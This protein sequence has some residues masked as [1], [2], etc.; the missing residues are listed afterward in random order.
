VG[1]LAFPYHDGRVSSGSSIVP[2]KLTTYMVFIK[3]LRVVERS[4]ILKLLEE[5]HISETGVIDPSTAKEM[6]RIL[7]I[8]VIVTGTLIDLGRGKTEI[9]AR[10]LMADTGEII[11][12]SQAVIKTTWS[13]RPRMIGANIV[14]AKKMK[15]SDKGNEAIEIGVPSR[16]GSRRRSLGRS[17]RGY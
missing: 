13:D 11:A 1:L 15:K 9:N 6:G 5:Q 14:K 7:G 12:A 16:G 8:D 3:G 2:E 4:L 17:Y 10:G